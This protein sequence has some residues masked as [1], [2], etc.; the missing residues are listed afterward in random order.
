MGL[1]N[2]PITFDDDFNDP[3]DMQARCELSIFPILEWEDF[4]DDGT[5]IVVVDF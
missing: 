3:E 4:N 5:E 2:E 1:W